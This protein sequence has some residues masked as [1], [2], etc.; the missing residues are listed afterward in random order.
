MWDSDAQRFIEEAEAESR[1]AAA[2]IA[3]LGETHDNPAH[4]RIQLRLLARSA[5]RSVPPALVMEQI[6]RERQ[7]AVDAARARG[8]DAAAIREAAHFSSGWSWQDYAPLVAY[9]LDR[10]LPLIAANF[11][12]ASA[13]PLVT[14]GLAA[15]PPGEAERLALAPAWSPQRTTMLRA[16]LVDGHCGQDD[17][18]I[19]KLVDIQRVRDAYMADAILSAPSGRAVAIIGDGHAR[20]DLGVPL[21]LHARSPARSVV[22]LG[23]IEVEAGKASPADYPDTAR[24]VHNLVW[25]TPRAP[26]SDPC[27]NLPR[28][29]RAS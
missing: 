10:G 29:P 1:I 7:A 26:R 21:Y 13:R 20:A 12:R 28:L 19:D 5:A 16:L 4:H 27:A 11:S 15:L 2:D 25:F 18:V 6:D 22:S 8:G 9:A 24:G 3:L 23:L 14:R 17:P